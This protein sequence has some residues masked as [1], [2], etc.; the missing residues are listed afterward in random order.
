[1][2]TTEWVDCMLGSCNKSELSLIYSGSGSLLRTLRTLR[3]LLPAGQRERRFG[4]LAPTRWGF[5]ATM[6]C[7]K[8]PTLS[9]RLETRVGG[10]QRRG[11]YT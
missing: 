1:M 2:P 10:Q 8:H 6:G 4:P 3:T 7:M 5:T 9:S 11:V